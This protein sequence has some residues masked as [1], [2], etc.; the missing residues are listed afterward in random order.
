[1]KISS[2][3]PGSHPPHLATTDRWSRRMFLKGA[4]ALGAASLIPG[5]LSPVV[6][7]PAPKRKMTIWLSAGAI[8]VRANQL[9]VIDLAHRHGFESVDPFGDYLASLSKEQLAE[10]VA[11]IKEKGLVFGAAGLPVDFRGDDARFREGL[12]NLPRIADGLRRAGVDRLGTWISPGHPTLTYYQNFNR[13]AQRL[14]EVARILREHGQ[15]LG[16]EYVGTKTLRARSRHPFIHS[17][18]ETQ[19]LIGA[20]GTG[21]V[22]VILDSWHWWQA[23]ETEDDLLGLSNDQ[24]V[25]ADLNDAPAGI[26]K[27]QQQDNRREL[28]AATGVIDAAAFL[29]ALNRIGFDGPVRAEPFN[30]ELNALDNDEACAAT[31]AAM[32]KAF[33]LIN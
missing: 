29:N 6:A 1:M 20:I 14:G 23:D 15:R 30:Q 25:A 13:H 9:E 3:P 17:L 31:I 19:D 27:D 7:A 18:A 21:N 22:G 28:P 5:S 24:I 8:G 4:T 26:P 2:K 10:L 12:G 11:S 16:L 33:A 32:R